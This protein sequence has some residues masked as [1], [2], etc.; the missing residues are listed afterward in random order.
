MPSQTIEQPPPQLSMLQ[1][2]PGP[3]LVM[4][5]LPLV[6]ACTRQVAAAPS[7]VILQAPRQVSMLQEPPA[8]HES[9][10]QAPLAQLL[11]RQVG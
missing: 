6:H 10:V 1:V 7:Q 2:A 4:P 8:L 5:Q 3:H 9:M 11:T